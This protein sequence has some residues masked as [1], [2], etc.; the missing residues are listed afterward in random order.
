MPNLTLLGYPHR[1]YI[2]P[3][4][5]IQYHLPLECCNYILMDNV[6]WL[7]INLRRFNIAKR[8]FYFIKDIRGV[9]LIAKSVFE[10]WAQGN[11]WLHIQDWK[12]TI[13]KKQIHQ[14]WLTPSGN[15]MDVST[16]FDEITDIQGGVHPLQYDE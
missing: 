16:D 15:I 14:V 4:F 8:T 6:F 5:Q 7:T 2:T 10:H 11:N 13:E 12:E 3:L 1:W 9:L